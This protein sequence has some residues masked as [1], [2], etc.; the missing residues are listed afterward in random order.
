LAVTQSCERRSVT[1][2]R[3]E[4]SLVSMCF[5]KSMSRKLDYTP[6]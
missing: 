1:E 6:V 4:G 3:A 5:I 2:E